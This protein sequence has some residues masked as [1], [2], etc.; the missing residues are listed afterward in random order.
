MI[1]LIGQTFGN[2]QIEALLGRGGMGQVYRARQVHTGRLAALKVISPMLAADSTFEARFR[3]EARAIAALHHTHIVQVY[4]FSE[5][6]GSCYMVMELLGQGSLRVLLDQY[7]ERGQRIPLPLGIDL[8]GQAAE[9]LSYAHGQ[10]MVH[11][12]IKPDNMLLAGQD[13]ASNA[14]VL[15]IADF[16]LA[17]LA[18]GSQ[19]TASGVAMGTPAYMSPEQ[20]RGDKVDARSD[21]YA[22][23]V[24]LYEVATGRLPFEVKTL[25]D[26]VYQHIHVRPPSPRVVCPDLPMALEKVILRCLEKQPSDRFA[27]AVALSDAL[28]SC[29]APVADTS[30]GI[31]ERITIQVEPETIVLTPGEPAAISVSLG[32]FG[33]LVDHLTIRLE[34]VP[35]NWL[36]GKPPVVQLNPGAQAKVALM[37]MVPR[38]PESR[39][40]EYPVTVRIR[41]RN[42]PAESG[43]ALTRW[44]IAPFN[45]DT[46]KLTPTRVYGHSQAYYWVTLVNHGNAPA[47]YRLAATDDEQTMIYTFVPEQPELEPGQTERVRLTVEQ[48]SRLIGSARPHTFTVQAQAADEPAGSTASAQFVQQALLPVWA[49]PILLLLLLAGGWWM[50]SE[51]AP[52]E[53]LATELPIAPTAA[54][55]ELPATPARSDTPTPSPTEPP[56]IAPA[57]TAASAAATEPP[58][59]A[60]PTAVANPANQLPPT[61][62]PAPAEPPTAATPTAVANPANQLP[63]TATPALAAAPSE[64]LAPAPTE[65]L[66]PAPISAPPTDTPAPSVTPVLPDLVVKSINP[67]AVPIGQHIKTRATIE[68][69]NQGSGAAAGFDVQWKPF[70]EHAGIVQSIPGLIGGTCTSL[71]AFEFAY[72]AAGDFTSSATVD[73]AGQVGEADESNNSRG[74]AMTVYATRP[75]KQFW[76]AAVNNEGDNATIASDQGEQDLQAAGYKYTR[77]EG[78]IFSSQAPG[79]VSLKQYWSKD[80]M[81]YAAFATP[82][83]QSDA[84]NSKGNYVYIRDEGYVFPN[85]VPGTVPLKKYWSAKRLENAIFATLEGQ[86]DAESS[87][88]DYVYSGIEGYIFP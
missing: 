13:S 80:R 4:D 72:P 29:L 58:T 19:L 51:L 41:S 45:A 37:I 86:N 31:A 53:T 79:T 17:H 1:N 56:T 11:R 9:A 10:G 18:E 57:P 71:L 66:A 7:R 15:K 88:A 28:Q 43:A 5:H 46:L 39:A 64:T 68:V 59:V 55:A 6:H 85:R 70:P 63:P 48:T 44:I 2:Y 84:E 77:V 67:A 83:G 27:S 23:G 87:L 26:A 62:A 36:T 21:I 74:Q 47:R 12:D 32:N 16:G 35:E 61:A 25:A 30:P 54:L 20:C 69:C 78:Y 75:L 34:G 22:L 3:Q 38:V 73:I 14:Y 49:I 33:Q 42:T 82:E 50:R 81:D 52:T 60:A 24:V 76:K 8:V 65:T 40:G